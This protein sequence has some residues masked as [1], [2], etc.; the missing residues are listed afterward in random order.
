MEHPRVVLPN[1]T[2][3]TIDPGNI[4]PLP[5]N[6][7]TPLTL[8]IFGLT[9]TGVLTRPRGISEAWFATAGA[10][11][12]LLLGTVTPLE[13]WKVTSES[14]DVLLFL[15]FLMALSALV[16]TSGFF[17]WAATLTA[18]GA[19]GNP[20]RLLVGLFLLG[21]IITTCLSLDTTALLLTPLV[22][23]VV[24]RAKLP[25]KP[26]GLSAG[27]V[28]NIASSAL[29]V[30]NLTNLLA[31]NRL[32]VTTGRYALIMTL[33]TIA[34]SLVALGVL[35]WRFRDELPATFDESAFPDPLD[36]VPHLPYFR[37]T[38]LVL[39]LTFAGYFVGPGIFHIP[40]WIVAASGAAILLIAGKVLGRVSFRTIALRGVAWSVFPF[41]IGMFVV[42]RAVEDVGL[43]TWLGHGLTIA[44][45]NSLGQGLFVTTFGTAIGSNLVNNIPMLVLSLNALGSGANRSLLYAAVLGC[46]LGPNIT[47]VGSLATML[48]RSV[49]QKR[50]LEIS[51]KELAI[52]GLL[53][54]IP[55]LIAA[56]LALWLMLSIVH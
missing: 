42:L 40:L 36:A 16:D 2:G 53:V 25:P 30:A 4:I 11:L 3:G 28:A 10:L 29:P 18:R 54:T 1:Q 17:D 34:A 19:R 48:W 33:P 6:L 55:S 31:M 8:G 39:V 7:Q 41:V 32:G 46:N 26:Y 22:W 14:G 56:T 38:L 44:S 45:G 21:A 43:S 47:I 15:L 9:L 20:R 37:I 35:L 13:A 49:L 52:N 50:G 27:F 51:P 24:S 12:L 23:A 5:A